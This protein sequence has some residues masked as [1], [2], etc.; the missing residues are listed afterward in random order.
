MNS[1]EL[2]LG[3]VN[4]GLQREKQDREQA[5]L[6]SCE[7]IAFLKQLYKEATNCDDYKSK[8]IIERLF[9]KLYGIRP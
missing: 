7:E 1:V 5:I 6:E 3:A 8:H 9:E 2:L 4:E